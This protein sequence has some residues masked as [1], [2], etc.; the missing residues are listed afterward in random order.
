MGFGR[1]ICVAHCWM[2]V[3]AIGL[4]R[5]SP[6]SWVANT[7][8][9]FSLRMVFKPSFDHLTKIASSRGFQNSSMTL[10]NGWPFNIA[11]VR[12]MRYIIM[13]VRM[14]GTSRKSV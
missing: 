10:I 2:I 8:R 5:A 13:G 6:G 1:K 7:R 11:S 3:R 14:I 9:P 4:S 12:C